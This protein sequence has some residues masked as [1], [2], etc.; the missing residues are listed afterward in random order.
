M[1]S[2]ETAER[3]TPQDRILARDF[4]LA[5]LG[6]LF[7]FLPVGAWVTV[8]LWHQLAAYE[9]PDAWEEAVEGHVNGATTALVFVLVLGPL[10]WHT[11]WG[12]VRMLRSRP[13]VGNTT[14]KSTAFN[15]LRYL[16]QRL[17]AVGLLAFLGAHLYLAWF[18]PRFLH[19]GPEPFSSISREMRFHTPTLVVYLLGVL[20]IA[21]HLANG[22]W[23]FMT[24]GWGVTVSKS[25]IAWME[26]VALAVFFVLLAIGLSAVYGLY[27]GGE[28]Y[29]PLG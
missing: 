11:V 27:S 8:H 17:S 22:L 23:S 3:T 26:R 15:N 14:V 2:S 24:M 25:G 18:E 5:R 4:L 20:G 19:G 21:Y 1:L 9:S 29:G 16:L 12:I 28:A 6:S 10:L 7:A 13:A